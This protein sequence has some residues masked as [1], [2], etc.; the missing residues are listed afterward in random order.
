VLITHKQVRGFQTFWMTHVVFHGSQLLT[1]TIILEALLRPFFVVIHVCWAGFGDLFFL[2][3]LFPLLLPWISH[4]SF[5]KLNLS[6][7]S[8]YVQVL[9]LIILI[10]ICFTFDVFLS[11]FVFQFIS[12]TFYFI[13]VFSLIL[14]FF[15]GNF[16][17]FFLFFLI[18]SIN[19][20]FHLILV[21][22]LTLILLIYIFLFFIIFL[23]YFI[24]QSSS[25]FFHLVFIPY[26]ILLF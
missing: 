26:S 10:V 13:F 6:F 24:F 23:I 16:L 4:Y 15:T 21:S 19:I 8:I 11:D 5:Q 2:S 22:K 7:E 9:L 17:L 3:S 1:S 18:S 20:L 25:L 14:V 12:S